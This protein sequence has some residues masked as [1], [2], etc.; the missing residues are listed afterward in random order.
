[1]N[2]SP[3]NRA[4]VMVLT[5]MLAVSGC[6]ITTTKPNTTPATT[7]VSASPSAS[8]S[9]S[10]TT[11]TVPTVV[12]RNLPPNTPSKAKEV[13]ND[14]SLV[15]YTPGGEEP[16]GPNTF[17]VSGEEIVVNASLIDKNLLVIY[18]NGHKI[19][20]LQTPE[21]YTC[22]IDLRVEGDRYWTL[23][24]DATE[25]VLKKGATRLTKVTRIA[26]PPDSGNAPV[27]GEIP[28][29]YVQW[30]GGLLERTDTGL[31]A[32]PSDGPTVRLEGTGTFPDGPPWH[33]EGKTLVIKDPGFTAKIR[34]RAKD[35]EAGVVSRYGDYVYYQITDNVGPN[36]GYIYQ[37]TTTGTLVHTYTLHQGYAMNPN[38]PIVITDNAQVYQLLVSTK[39]ARVLRL[40]PN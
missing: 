21:Q 24:D 7:G 26:L 28:D 1:M 37:F 18:R 34:T 5:G 13:V 15:E 22:C 17:S 23:G 36:W 38:R 33:N 9:R 16:Q 40:P 2:L 10:A 27:T 39:T 14:P 20:T 4:T 29:D 12:V 30:S 25:W 6:T 3:R 11:A 8:P 31:F 35:A 32:V 19:R